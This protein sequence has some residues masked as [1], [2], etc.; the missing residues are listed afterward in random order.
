[1]TA[2]TDKAEK[3]EAYVSREGGK[4]RIHIN[5]VTLEIVAEDDAP[6]PLGWEDGQ[7]PGITFWKSNWIKKQGNFFEHGEQRP[8]TSEKLPKDD[9]E[10]IM[11]AVNDD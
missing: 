3:V 8:I 9:V 6:G 2:M 11:E 1:M 10:R 5:S 7:D 4:M